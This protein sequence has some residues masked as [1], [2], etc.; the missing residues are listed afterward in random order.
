MFFYIRDNFIG[1]SMKLNPFDQ[2][3]V[4]LIKKETKKFYFN[5]KT[6]IQFWKS[7]IFFHQ[8]T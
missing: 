8:L 2:P 3:A 5:R 4:E 7:H 6:Q 1:Q